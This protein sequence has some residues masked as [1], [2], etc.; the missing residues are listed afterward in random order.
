MI[1]FVKLDDF[2]EATV[3]SKD[4]AVIMVG[5][6]SDM[7]PINHWGKVI[8]VQCELLCL[9][10]LI[11]KCNFCRSTIWHGGTSHGFTV[12]FEHSWK[13]EK[14]KNTSHCGSIFCVTTELFSGLL[15][16]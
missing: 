4:E 14:A 2:V 8:S 13:K 12:T 10:N 5:N 16:I 1:A 9:G 3:Y 11:L 6:F 15:R 7:P